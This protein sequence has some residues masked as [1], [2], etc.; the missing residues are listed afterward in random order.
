M[1]ER[2][3]DDAVEETVEELLTDPDAPEHG[4]HPRPPQT[5]DAEP[6]GPAQDR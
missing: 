3:R 4:R 1:S 5:T 2:E 6:S